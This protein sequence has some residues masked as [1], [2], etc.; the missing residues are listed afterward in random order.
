[1]EIQKMAR[2]TKMSGRKYGKKFA[3]ARKH[4]RAINS[5]AFVMRGG[6]RL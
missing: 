4:T 5:P 2:R 3:K 6:I 1:M